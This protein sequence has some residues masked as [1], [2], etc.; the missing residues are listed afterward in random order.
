MTWNRIALDRHRGHVKKMLGQEEEEEEEE[1]AGVELLGVVAAARGP[2]T[3]T[4]EHGLFPCT[5]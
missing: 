4:K 2:K 5:R 1:E 3:S